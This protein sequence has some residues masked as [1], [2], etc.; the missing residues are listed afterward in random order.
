MVRSLLRD[1]VR[2]ATAVLGTVS[3]VLV[4]AAAGQRIPTA[5]LPDAPDA[6]LDAI[7]HVNAGVSLLAIVTISAGWREIRRGRVDRHRKLMGASTLLFA[8]FLVLYL[9]RVALLGP[10]GFPGPDAVYTFLYLPLLAIHILLAMICVPLLWFVGLLAATRSIPEIRESPHARVGRVAA[11]L[12]LVS[13]S[14][15]VV[16]Y[17]LLYVVY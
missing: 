9:Y 14:L 7:P 2:E 13:F 6:V 5:L 16:V 1:N 8:T 4:F 11:A 12:W 17:L 15:G 10:H 3:L